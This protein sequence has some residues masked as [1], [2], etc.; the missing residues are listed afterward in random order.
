MSSSKLAAAEAAA[1]STVLAASADI[2]GE[3]LVD[4]KSPT[5]Q[6]DMNSKFKDEETKGT[7]AFK[8]RLLTRTE[9]RKLLYPLL[10]L[11]QACVHP[12]IGSSGIRSLAAS[13]RPMS[14]LEVLDV[15]ITKATVEAE[16]AQRQLIFSLNG[17]AG[18]L[19]LQGKR[20]EASE[21]YR[22]ALRHI[23]E[24]KERKVETDP[25][26]QIH[27]MHNLL[28]LLDTSS[29]LGIARTL[30]D[31][32]MRRCIQSLRDEY[33]A[34]AVAR[35]EDVEQKMKATVRA[36]E[37]IKGDLDRWPSPNQRGE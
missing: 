15:L 7:S 21:A 9:E 31:D 22:E 6:H 13:R 3:R 17:L 16:E 1:A 24:S 8:D 30:R 2:E 12:Q 35:L 37:D 26:L 4:A 14:M 33:C 28:E 11:R 32:D 23:R 18:L 27:T 10:R 20:K 36:I 25:L 34:E 29:D 19:L 5:N